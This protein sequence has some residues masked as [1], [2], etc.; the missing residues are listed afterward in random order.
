MKSGSLTLCRT[1]ACPRAV[2]FDAWTTLEHRRQWF[3]GPAWTE[4]ARSVELAV[5]GREI[6][7]GRFANGI[8]TIYTARFHL[9]EPGF[10]LIY[11]FDMQVGGA[12]F[13]V[14]LA[15]V[16]FAD[17]PGGS[18]LTYTEQAFFLQGDYDAT[19]REAGT[20]GLLNQYVAHLARSQ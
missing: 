20:N 7:H 3:V 4:I 18:E 11:D 9:I 15:G 19:A 8:E 14:S 12:L 13:S 17:V 6:A 5:G 10:R 16:S 1:L 2:A